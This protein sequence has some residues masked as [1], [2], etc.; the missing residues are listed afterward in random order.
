[1][2]KDK[3][4]D[5]FDNTLNTTEGGEVNKKK[6]P[7]HNVG[8]Y[9]NLGMFTKLISNHFVFHAKLQ[10]FLKKEEPNYNVDS[11]KEASEF[12]VFNRAFSYLSKVNPLNKEVTFM[13]L[14]FNSKLLSQTLES[15]IQYFEEEE[16]FEKCA[17][18]F[19]F[20]KIIKESKR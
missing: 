13:V 18:I 15:A 3:I 6:V 12:V 16:E 7:V 9:Y 2:D 19:K 8:S 14:D 1:V 17:H 5:L 11:T 10:K 4:F 20:Q